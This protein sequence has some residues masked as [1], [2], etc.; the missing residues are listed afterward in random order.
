MTPF[1]PFLYCRSNSID[2]TY[3]PLNERQNGDLYSN[4]ECLNEHRRSSQ[5]DVS[6]LKSSKQNCSY[7]CCSSPSSSSETRSSCWHLK[8]RQIIRQS[9]HASGGYGKTEGEIKMNFLSEL[10]KTKKVKYW[11]KIIPLYII[12]IKIRR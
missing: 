8:R 4:D 10:S 1:S 3:I 11:Q 9:S 7:C 5:N 12:L 2:V 6:S